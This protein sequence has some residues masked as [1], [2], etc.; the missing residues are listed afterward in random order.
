[1]RVEEDFLAR[2]SRGPGCSPQETSYNLNFISTAGPETGAG[3]SRTGA[4]QENVKPT[5]A[6]PTTTS[7]PYYPIRDPQ[8]Y[9][10]QH[11]HLAEDDHTREQA[12]LQLQLQADVQS[13]HTPSNEVE[14]VQHMNATEQEQHMKNVEEERL[15]NMMRGL[16]LRVSQVVREQLVQL[17]DDFDTDSARYTWPLGNC[18]SS[19]SN[20]STGSGESSFGSLESAG[21]GHVRGQGR[22]EEDEQEDLGGGSSRRR[23]RQEIQRRRIHSLATAA[24]LD[25][26]MAESVERR[27]GSPRSTDQGQ[28]KYYYLVADASGDDH[29]GVGVEDANNVEDNQSQTTGGRTQ[30]SVVLTRKDHLLREYLKEKEK[31]DIQYR[32]LAILSRTH[33]IEGGA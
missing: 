5:P 18:N 17:A 23:R 3:A 2:T 7:A 29:E 8:Q 24:S 10:L 15:Q 28:Q 14:V 31:A 6:R 32:K 27:I 33:S 21:Y 19:S 30:T 11:Q 12:G 26:S 16:S 1:M 22:G 9:D 25:S 13:A 4:K 20:S